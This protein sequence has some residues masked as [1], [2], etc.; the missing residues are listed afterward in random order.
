MRGIVTSRVLG[1][2]CRLALG[3]VFIWAS[4]DKLHGSQAFADALDNYQILPRTTINAFALLLPWVQF[5]TGICLVAGWPAAGASFISAVL[6]ATFLGAMISA[7]V[8]GLNIE[9][10]CFNLDNGEPV[11][12]LGLWPRALGLLAS[13]QALTS[14]YSLD[15]PVSLLVRKR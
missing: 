3:A 15:W 9:C 5:V 11:R 2:I 6:Y 4:H 12:W 8:R 13:L 1:L 14:S 7:L 10:G